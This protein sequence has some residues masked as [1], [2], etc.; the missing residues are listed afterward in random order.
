MYGVGKIDSDPGIPALIQVPGETTFTACKLCRQRIGK[1]ISHTCVKRKQDLTNHVAVTKT[2]SVEIGRLPEKH[3]LQLA[4]SILNRKRKSLDQSN[5]VVLV[6]Q[7]RYI[8]ITFA[9]TL[10]QDSTAVQKDAILSTWV[11]QRWA[12][13]WLVR[14]GRGMVTAS[15]SV[16]SAQGEGGSIA[17]S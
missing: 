15:S 2:L 6:D 1:G 7:P 8:L 16:I 12:K 5:T 17:S 11:E 9:G 10:S 3:Q 13:P 14:K 4:R